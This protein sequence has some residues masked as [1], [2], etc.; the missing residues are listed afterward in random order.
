M[1]MIFQLIS[2]KAIANKTTLKQA[3]L[4]T[5]HIEK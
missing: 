1:N 5:K 3:E 2:K 4:V